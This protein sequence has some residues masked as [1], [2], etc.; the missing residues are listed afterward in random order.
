MSLTSLQ[1]LTDMLARALN[2]PDQRTQLISEFQ[3]IIWHA[4]DLPD[5]WEYTLLRD[6][7]YDLDFYE[8]DVKARN[9]DA[10]Y[11]GEERLQ[12]EI[13]EALEKLNQR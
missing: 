2:Q 4:E 3:R 13:N 7:A 9:E 1:F 10:S 12:I 8:P 6:L 11:Y 5:S